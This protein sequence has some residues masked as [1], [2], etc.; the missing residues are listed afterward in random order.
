MTQLH[1][2]NL[3][4]STRTTIH[5][6]TCQMDYNKID[7]HDQ[8]LHI[9]HHNSILNGPPFP[10]PPAISRPSANS[11]LSSRGDLVIITRS[12]SKELQ[13]RALN[14]LLIID[15]VLG[16]PKNVNRQDFFPK[17]GKIY[18]LCFSGRVISL[19][20]A[21]RIEFAFRRIP[22]DT[23]IETSGVKEKADVGISRM[24]TC[25]SERGKGWCTA[26]LDECAAGFV[27][28]VDYRC[29]ELGRGS[30]ELRDF[31]AF[32]TPSES[33]MGVA[34]KWTGKEDFLVY[35]D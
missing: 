27:L 20:A 22:S 25:I 24:W 16:A 11:P 23:G 14:L 2:A 21:Q 34:R 12:S 8:K 26:L 6:K 33:G 29:R 17:D 31:V 4:P 3:G 15:T 13:K 5:C 9:K 28:G 32:S 7:P 10:K 18:T 1:L 35:D 30:R 19:V